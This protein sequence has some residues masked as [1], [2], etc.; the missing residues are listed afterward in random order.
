[1]N[2]R[3]AYL[4]IRNAIRLENLSSDVAQK[5]APQLRAIFNELGNQFRR[6]PAGNIEREMWYR[7]QRLRIADMLASLS[8]EMRN[9]LT[10]ALGAEVAQQMHYAESYLRI[11]GEDPA[12]LVAAAAPQDGVSLGLDPANA[13]AGRPQF[14]RT[15]LHA[16]TQETRVLGERLEDLFEPTIGKGDMGPWIRQNVNVID[17]VVKAG[18]LT[19]QTNEQIAQQLPGGS[20]EAIARNKAIARTAVMDLSANAQEAF[21][22]ANSDRV[23]GW[24]FDASMDNRV[25]PQCAPWDGESRTDRSKLPATPLHVNCRCRVLPLTATELALR[26]EDG[27]QRRSVIELIDSPSKEAAIAKAKLK[28]GATDARAY[29]S[30]VRVKGKKYWRVA[31]DIK[32]PDG[33]LTMG[34]FLKQASPATQAEVLG[35]NKRRGIFMRKITGDK[36]HPPMSPERALKETVEW[37]PTVSRKPRMDAQLRLDI[38][39]LKSQ[40]EEMKRNAEGEA[41]IVYGYLRAKDSGTG[42][43]GSPYYVGI[44][45]SH[46]RAFAT[47]YRMRDGA[48]RRYGSVPVPKNEALVRQFGVFKTKEEAAAREQALIARFG[49]KGIDKDGILLNRSIGGEHGSI[50]AKPSPATLARRAAGIKQARKPLVAQTA[51]KY[52]VPESVYESMSEKERRAAVKYLTNNEGATWEMYQAGITGHDIKAAARLGLDPFAYARLTVSGRQ[53]LWSWLKRNPGKTGAD[54]LARQ[55]TRQ[56][57]TAIGGGARS[58]DAASAAGVP[59]A[60]WERLSIAERGDLSRWASRNPGRSYKDWINARAAGVDA[61]VVAAAAKYGVPV[62]VWAQLSATLRK[63]IVYRHSQGKRG[64]ALLEGLI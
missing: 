62:E 18:F 27:P 41:Y 54:Y 59:F 11:A 46:K 3:Q 63:K 20:R 1:M 39:R 13:V 52:G 64:A 26:E 35:S 19:G 42:K 25:C 32:K 44:G 60:E 53:S 23:K 51:K 12:N 2:E 15:Q 48:A 10:Q 5:V 33:P 16:I 58:R 61:R 6:V 14:T 7:Q 22:Q 9:Q 4:A 21:W 50:G 17:R 49:R 36:N 57:G 40:K 43:A 56:V 28:P 24:E 37:K 45:N 47:H 31:V 55:Q 34:E 30:Q 8:I 38:E 29:A